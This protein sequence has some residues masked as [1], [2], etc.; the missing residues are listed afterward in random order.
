MGYGR[1]KGFCK[2]PLLSF[3]ELIAL[4]FDDNVNNSDIVCVM[5]H[6]GA[7]SVLTD[8]YYEKTNEYINLMMT[9]DMNFR[10]KYDE[11]IEYIITKGE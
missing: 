6:W 1:E 8:D 5:N 11:V 10:K 2:L 7:I 3:E 4:A 9:V